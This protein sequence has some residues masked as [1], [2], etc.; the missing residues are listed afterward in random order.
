[1]IEIIAFLRSQNMARTPKVILLIESSRGSG[2]ALLC[3]IAKYAHSHGPWSFYWE[4][5]G[6]EPALPLVES[7]DADG[8]I[9]R[10]VDK[11]DA[12]LSLGIPAV[13]VG[14]RATAIS[15]TVNAVSDC[16]TIARIAAEHLLNCGFKNF[17]YCGFANTALEQ[18]WWSRLRNEH[19]NERIAMA[20][21][22]SPA[23]YIL[24]T[25]SQVWQD[26]R[27]ALAQWLAS[28]PKPLGV[29]ACNDDCGAQVMEACK[30]AGLTVP[31]AVGIVGVDN[32]EVICGLAD[33]PMS[34]VVV[35]FE[36]AGYEAAEVL[37]RLMHR[38]KKVPSKIV[39]SA[40]HVVT[41]R[42]TDS[43]A[44]EDPHLAKSLRFVRDHAREAIGVDDVAKSV[45]ISRRA[46][47]RLFRRQMGF[48]IL[49]EIR[50]ARNGEIARLLLETQL[51]IR[52]IADAMGFED[53]QHFARYFRATKKMSPSD[54]RKT[55]AGR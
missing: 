11:L 51:S 38:S 14:H 30:L 8:I 44:I 50:R 2:R 1:V 40:S 18:T 25:R 37:N 45:G 4:P 26:E 35:H 43:V 34:S 20:G 12:V 36:K 53:V 47:E 15:G 10:D 54:Y 23:N 3:G 5:G 49:D 6:L 55:F 52:Q 27:R 7:F 21:F 17:A 42:S 22:K 19:F 9:L 39:I 41:R 32:D 31:D 13:V 48:S 28:L 24:S 33:P 16:A 46:L 29:M